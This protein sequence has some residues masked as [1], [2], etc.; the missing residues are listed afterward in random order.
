MLQ[1]RGNPWSVLRHLVSESAE[2]LLEGK[3][4]EDCC[5]RV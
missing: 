5:L 4:R 1:G 2:G 3:E